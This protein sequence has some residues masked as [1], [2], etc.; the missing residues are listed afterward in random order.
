MRKNCRSLP[1]NRVEKSNSGGKGDDL[2]VGEDPAWRISFLEKD[3]AF[4]RTNLIP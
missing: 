3:D 2:Q 4:R 1:A